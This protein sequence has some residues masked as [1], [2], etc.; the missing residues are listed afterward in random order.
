ML[1]IIIESSE[2]TSFFSIF[3][4]YFPTIAFI[5]LDVHQKKNKT[6]V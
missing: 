6:K 3:F 1:L 2:E 4:L 5:M